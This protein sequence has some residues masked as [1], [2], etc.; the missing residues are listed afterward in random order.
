M[1][2]GVT[3][4]V[5]LAIILI[6]IFGIGRLPDIRRNRATD[7]KDNKADASGDE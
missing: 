5:I 1:M 2:L 7:S 3:E 4:I 6:V